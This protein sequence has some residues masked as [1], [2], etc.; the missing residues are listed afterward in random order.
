MPE[1]KD[2]ELL[3]T[4]SE[5]V[6]ALSVSVFMDTLGKEVEEGEAANGKKRMG[7]H[8]GTGSGSKS[9]QGKRSNSPFFDAD[10]RQ[11]RAAKDQEAA[12][13]TF[14]ADT[15]HLLS[16]PAVAA[17]PQAELEHRL[18]RALGTSASTTGIPLATADI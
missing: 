1:R 12:A 18:E 3:A 14:S 10:T 9:S 4:R 8:K 2:A 6:D 7:T 11:R 16:T 5:P 15:R 13:S 17:I